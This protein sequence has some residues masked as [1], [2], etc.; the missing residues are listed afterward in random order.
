[1]NGLEVFGV[2]LFI[3]GAIGMF[4]MWKGQRPDYV[5][6]KDISRKK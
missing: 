6:T 2:L 4:V 1:M 5:T 3:F